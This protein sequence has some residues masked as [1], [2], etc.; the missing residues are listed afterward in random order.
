LVPITNGIGIKSGKSRHNDAISI[1]LRCWTIRIFCLFLASSPLSSLKNAWQKWTSI[2]ENNSC[3]IY[4]CTCE[5]RLGRPI[6]RRMVHHW[7]RDSW[8]SFKLGNDSC[9]HSI[10]SLSPSNNAL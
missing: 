4:Y 6:K 3:L 9:K 8:R 7:E 1:T 2:L 5:Q 10:K